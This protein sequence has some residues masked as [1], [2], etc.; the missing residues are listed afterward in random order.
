MLQALTGLLL[1]MFVSMIANTVVSTSM[2]VIIHDIGGDQTAYTWVI[3]S[4]LL[5]TAIATPI[6]GKLADL[7]NRKLQLGHNQE[8]GG[9]FARLIEDMRRDAEAEDLRALVELC[10]T[11]GRRLQT[12]DTDDRLA[13]SYPFLTMFSTAVCGWLM[14][15]QLRAAGDRDDAF[16]RTKRAVVRFYLDQVVPEA[17]GLRAAATQPAAP[18][19]ALEAEAFAA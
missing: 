6:W 14:E 11:V 1:G 7:V 8:G 13:A 9:V 10:D 3:T 2:P 12:A 4:A 19:Y 5:A 18:L 15:R 16:G 17:L